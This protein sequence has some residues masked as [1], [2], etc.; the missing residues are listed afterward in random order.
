MDSKKNSAFKKNGSGSS[1]FKQAA[2]KNAVDEIIEVVTEREVIKEMPGN[3]TIITTSE[4]E[5]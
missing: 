5:E 4:I 3:E 1:R 2:Q